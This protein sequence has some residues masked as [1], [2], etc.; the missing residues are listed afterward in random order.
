MDTKTVTQ[1]GREAKIEQESAE[2]MERVRAEGEG[3]CTGSAL[4]ETK[5]FCTGSLQVRRNTCV[6]ASEHIS[7]SKG[8]HRRGLV[9]DAGDAHVRGGTREKGV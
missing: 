6:T 7:C 8:L 5:R 4:G 2:L 9:S 3:G 1:M